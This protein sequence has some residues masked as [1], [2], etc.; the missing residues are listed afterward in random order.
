MKS[1]HI[2]LP[3]EGNDAGTGNELDL[4]FRPDEGVRGGSSRRARDRHYGLACLDLDTLGSCSAQT[5]S[6]AARPQPARWA[7]RIIANKPPSSPSG[8]V[9]QGSRTTL[10]G[11]PQRPSL[12]KISFHRLSLTSVLVAT[13]LNCPPKRGSSTGTLTQRA[14]L[15]G[16]G[17][18]GESL[19]ID[20]PV[21]I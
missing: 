18:D 21:E 20:Y 4:G 16:A 2:D 11:D 12:V 13:P 19:C 5:N 17:H 14:T 7:P 8:S 3:S 9:G 1:V 15:R 6:N 10:R